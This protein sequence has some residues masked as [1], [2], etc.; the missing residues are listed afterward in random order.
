MSTSNDIKLGDVVQLASGG[1][2]MTVGSMPSKSDGFVTCY[3]FRDKGAMAK[4]TYGDFEEAQIRI[5]A[6]VKAK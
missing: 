4:E 1:Q 5:G 2:E 3:W 6:L